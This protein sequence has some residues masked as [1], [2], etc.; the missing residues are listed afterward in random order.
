MEQSKIRVHTPYFNVSITEET[1]SIQTK[2][3]ETFSIQTKKNE[4]FSKQT[5]KNETFSIQTKIFS[6]RFKS[7][8][9][10]H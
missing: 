10:S 2:R 5:K 7:F 8:K 1:F 6:L 3:N 9:L 4:T